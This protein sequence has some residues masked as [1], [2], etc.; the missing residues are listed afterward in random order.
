MPNIA[1]ISSVVLPYRQFG[2]AKTLYDMTRTNN[3]H[4]CHCLASDVQEW[5]DIEVVGSTDHLEHETLVDLVELRI[6]GR[7]LNITD[8]TT[9]LPVKLS[10]EVVL[11]A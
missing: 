6:P 5:L 8:T 1:L 7:Y 3:D 2:S 11:A 4:L 9:G 10:A